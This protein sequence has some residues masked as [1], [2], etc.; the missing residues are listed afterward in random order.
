MKFSD[1][2]MIQYLLRYCDKRQL[3]IQTVTKMYDVRMNMHRFQCRVPGMYVSL[4]HYIAYEDRNKVDM[5]I[6]LIHDHDVVKAMI[7]QYRK[8]KKTHGK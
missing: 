5:F 4:F 7:D 1:L 8:M 3:P 6:S 2:D